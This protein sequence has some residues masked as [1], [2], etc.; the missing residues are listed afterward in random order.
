MIKQNF[1]LRSTIIRSRV[2][3]GGG[4]ESKSS[5][6]FRGLFWKIYDTDFP[7]SRSCISICL[8][9]CEQWGEENTRTRKAAKQAH[10]ERDEGSS[11]LVLLA[12]A[13][14]RSVYE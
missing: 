2:Y 1:Q 14:Q 7:S 10:R 6:P 9:M 8:V 3:C 13:A 5:F 11:V 4:V 12:A